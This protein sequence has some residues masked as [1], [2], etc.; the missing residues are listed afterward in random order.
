MKNYYETLNVDLKA[1]P[2]EIK[3]GYFS[4][5]RKYPSDRFPQE[6]MDIR[7]AYEALSN[8]KTREEYDHMMEMSA[9]DR[10][11]FEKSRQL[12][13]AGETKKAIKILEFILER[14]FDSSLVQGLLAE[15][16]L[17]NGNSGKAI[18]I[19]EKLV[20]EH[21]GN[22]GFKGHLAHAYIERGWHKKAIKAYEDA[23]EIDEDNL[24][25]WLGLSKAYA[26]GQWMS[27]AKSV[28]LRALEKGKDKDWDYITLY[29]TLIHIE[30]AM[31]DLDEM[32]KSVKK[33]SKASLEKE[34]SREH[35]GWILSQLSQ[36]LLGNGFME[37]AM[38][39]LEEAEVLLPNNE[40]IQMVRKEV[41]SFFDLEKEFE[42]LMLDGLIEEDI[43]N[44]MELE[45]LPREM[46]G[47][48]EDHRKDLV[49]MIEYRILEEIHLFRK[50]INRLK[51]KYPR[52][53]EKKANFF[54]G[55]MD[56]KRRG[57]MARS[58]EKQGK[59]MHR[60]IQEMAMNFE[61]NYEDDDDEFLGYSEYQE[62]HVREEPKIG[63]NEPC[64]CGSG[65]KY[66]KCCGI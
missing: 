12:V 13:Q 22:A 63:R 20:E 15:A 38:V 24:S 25:L 33:L 16:Y 2:I 61:Q 35:I 51:E 9:W 58:Y 10:E 65:K 39:L 47:L 28:L 21:P 54:E 42:K 56:P 44:L 18:K 37:E 4:L 53:Y 6:F 19:L 29:L 36:L 1:S 31:G 45:V 62:P 59:R 5:V 43:R 66:K 27:K 11:F 52:I 41:Q 48:E 64:P 60:I 17:C 40:E 3:R 50:S 23:L 32:K 14:Q 55:A 26:A 30:L 8:E 7:E 49:F 34:E 57:K 46:L